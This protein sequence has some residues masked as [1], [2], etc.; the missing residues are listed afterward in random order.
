VLNESGSLRDYGVQLRDESLDDVDTYIAPTAQQ[1]AD[2][3]I[4]AGHVAAGNLNL[5]DSLAGPLGYE[6]VN[7]TDLDTNA[8]FHVLREVTVGAPSKVVNGWGTYFYNPNSIRSVLIQAPHIRHDTHSYDVATVAFQHS[9]AS[10]ML[11]NGAHRDSNGNNASDV[12]DLTDSIFQ[13]VHETWTTDASVQAWQIH[14]FNLDNS[15]HNTNPSAI[16]P[17]TDAVLSNGDGT[18]SAEIKDLDARLEAV[19]FINDTTSISHVYNTLAVGDPDN[20]DVNQTIVGTAMTS[21]GG[22]TNVQGIYTR[23]QGGIF[24]HIELE[25]SIRLDGTLAEDKDN[26]ELAGLAIADAIQ[27]IPEP[28]SAGLILSISSG[29]FVLHRRKRR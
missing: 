5:A 15:V 25:Q 16:P 28:K 17:G 18:V 24:V 21:L 27:A 11:F 7:Y 19:S 4:M 9:G 1:R 22:T 3:A 20:V 10:A 29:L 2:F 26:R 12:A 14:G 23:D 6:V 8:V 13:T